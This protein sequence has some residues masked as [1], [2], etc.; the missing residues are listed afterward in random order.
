MHWMILPYRRYFDFSGR[1]RRMEYWMFVLFNLAV[2]V[3]ISAVFGV[4]D[5]QRSG[6]MVGFDSRLTGV[7]GMV[8][9]LFG[10]V[11]FIPGMAVA[12]RRLHDQDRSGWLM[13]LLL[14]PFFGWFAL[15]VM[16]LLSGTEGPNRF[17]QDPKQR[18]DASAFD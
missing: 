4:Q 8:Q 16:M 10:L 7:G 11:S 6:L 13:L 9:N 1:S 2:A 17:G 15:F 5:V 3:V 12:I 14:I 18:Y